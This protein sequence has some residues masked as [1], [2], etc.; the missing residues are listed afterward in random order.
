MLVR[1]RWCLA[2]LERSIVVPEGKKVKILI[3]VF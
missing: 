2:S 3:K 1:E